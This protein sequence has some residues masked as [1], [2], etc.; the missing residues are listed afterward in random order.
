MTKRI[1][2]LDGGGI[3]GAATTEFLRKLEEKLNKPL[4]SIFDLFVGTSTG[5]I[6]AAA[7]SVLKM[8]GNDLAELY[9]HNNGTE[10]FP[11]SFWD[12]TLL[13]QNQPKYDGIGKRNVLK[14]YFGK[15][16][17][18]S[19]SKPLIL[20]AYDVERRI[21]KIFKS[22]DKDNTKVID[23]V[24]AT[25][26]APTYFPTVEVNGA[27]LID[28]GVI[29]NNPTMTAYAEAKKIW[30]DD[31]I[32]ILSVGTGKRTRP[33][34]GQESSEYGAL[35]WFAHDLIGIVT[36]ETIVHMQA[37][38][39]LGDKYLRVN[40]ELKKADDDMDNV[41]QGNLDNLKNLGRKW[42]NDYG[43]KA[44]SLLS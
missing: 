22:Y 42:W 8:P 5:G 6:I 2:A 26:A 44:I 33:I 29:V 43:Q 40:S 7:I 20:T 9:N 25:S 19:S 10:I 24:D 3:R 11:Q 14:K 17:L 4:H 32:Q 39:I 21:P 1:L 28:G 16:L 38:T 13:A 23:A 30:P 15:R 37:E 34:P 31:N 12:R 18:R 36:D 35:R 27:W 41:K